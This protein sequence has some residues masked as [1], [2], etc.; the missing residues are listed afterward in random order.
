MTAP[1]DR[2]PPNV[3]NVP[4]VVDLT[5]QPCIL[6][7]TAHSPP[8]PLLILTATND[9]GSVV[10]VA[11]PVPHSQPYVDRLSRGAAT[12]QRMALRAQLAPPREEGP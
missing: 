6:P 7:G 1:A 2:N 10:Q 5:A 11:L 3:T 4:L 12:A 8:V 9:D